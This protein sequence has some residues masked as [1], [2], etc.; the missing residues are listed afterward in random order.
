MATTVRRKAKFDPTSDFAQHL[1]L[2]ADAAKITKRSDALK[3]RLKD[4][5]SKGAPEVRENENGSKFLDLDETITVDGVDYS[6]MELRRTVPTP[7][8]NEETAEKI[9]KR[10]AAKDPEIVQDAQSS[11]IDQ[12]KIY[13]LLQ[14][15]R[16]TEKDVEAMFEEQDPKWA[17]WPVKGEVL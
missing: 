9:L 5:L 6:G 4:F 15:D 3:A 13:R 16:L 10:K 8:F 11:Y 7:L 2:K 14:E 1:A 17:F 12:D